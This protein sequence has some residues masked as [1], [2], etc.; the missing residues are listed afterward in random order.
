[1]SYRCLA[2]ATL[3]GG[4]SCILMVLGPFLTMRIHPEI[5]RIEEELDNND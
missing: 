1:M 5:R 2:G 4:P 3:L